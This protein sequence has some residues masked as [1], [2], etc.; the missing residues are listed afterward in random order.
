[1]ETPVENS[2]WEATAKE[3]PRSTLNLVN[4]ADEENHRWP[5]KILTHACDSAAM[6]YVESILWAVLMISLV[7]QLSG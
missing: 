5:S 2:P 7:M 3:P 6:K 4:D 1:M